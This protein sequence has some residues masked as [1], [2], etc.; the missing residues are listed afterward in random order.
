M[1]WACDAQPLAPY[2]GCE[3]LFLANKVVERLVYLFFLVSGIAGE[4]GQPFC[5]PRLRRSELV[6][7]ESHRG[8]SLWP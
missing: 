3:R 1:A 7:V 8:R 4:W 2:S 6:M 5:G